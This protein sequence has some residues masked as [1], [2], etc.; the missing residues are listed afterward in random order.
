[1]KH[2]EIPLYTGILGG[3]AFATHFFRMANTQM[4]IA[5]V[6]LSALGALVSIGL[7]Y[8]LNKIYRNEENKSFTI[9]NINISVLPF[10]VLFLFLIISL[11]SFKLR[12]NL[13]HLVWGLIIS[14]V[15]SLV[16]LLNRFL[17]NEVK[18]TSLIKASS[19]FVVLTLLALSIPTSLH[20]YIW[21]SSPC[22]NGQCRLESHENH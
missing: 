16:V 20:L 18:R 11:T 22:A 4:I 5:L 9:Q 12:L 3:I 17:A 1:M 13:E 15:I 6:V 2:K 7:Q 19:V 21:N 10:S 14:F 8:L